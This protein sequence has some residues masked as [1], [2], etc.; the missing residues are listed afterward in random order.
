MTEAHRVR[1]LLCQDLTADTMIPCYEHGVYES[2][3][4]WKSA[5]AA[6]RDQ[7]Q[8][9]FRKVF[10]TSQHA[11]QLIENYTA[12]TRTLTKDADH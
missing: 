9:A 7:D 2:T 5:A 3:V 6:V 10:G 1:L 4:C 8:T 11:L 12:L